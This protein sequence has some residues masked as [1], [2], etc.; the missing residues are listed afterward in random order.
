MVRFSL[1]A[2]LLVTVATAGSAQEKD[3]VVRWHGQAFFTVMTP[4]GKTIAF[5]PQVMREF[6]RKDTLPADYVCI[7]HEHNDHNRADEAIT[8]AKDAT[9]V[10]IFRGMKPVGKA[11]ADKP[12]MYDWNKLDEKVIAGDSTYR[13]RTFGCYH[14]ENNGLKRGKNTAFIVEADGLTFCHLGDLG[15]TF[16]EAEA[17]VIGKIDVLFVPIGGTY[18]LNGEGAK[19]VID[20]LKPRLY[21]IPMHYAVDN[22]PDSLV[23]ADEFLEAFP[24]TI[25]MMETNEFVINRAMKAEKM[26]TVLLNFEKKRK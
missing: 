6:D 5:D 21:A 25:K 17:K 2:V 1:A 11:D 23:G 15:H 14:D 10:R 24:N 18:T 4:G 16:T 22:T 3:F 26:T 9:K 20:M 19:D 8:D 13:F 7:S 12:Q